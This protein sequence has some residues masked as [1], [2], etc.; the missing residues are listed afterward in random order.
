MTGL[1]ERE[2]E[3]HDWYAR[4]AR[5]RGH[6][7]DCRLV[8]EPRNWPTMFGRPRCTCERPGSTSTPTTERS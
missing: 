5:A 3:L 8:T 1:T 2:R 6:A 7:D 4:N